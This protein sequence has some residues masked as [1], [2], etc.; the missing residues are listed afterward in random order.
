M[1]GELLITGFLPP[2]SKN[3]PKEYLAVGHNPNVDPTLVSIYDTI[4]RHRICY[5][6]DK[7]I[8]SY[9]QIYSNLT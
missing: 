6:D 7:M 5:N 8:I 4:P 3:S 1:H 2:D 9:L